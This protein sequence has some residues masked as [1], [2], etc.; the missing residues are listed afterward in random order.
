MITFKQYLTE[1]F[2]KTYSA[3]FDTKTDN[4]YTF[5]F[6]DEDKKKYYVHISRKKYNK[7]DYEGNVSFGVFDPETRETSYMPS[8]KAK[9]P[10]KVYATVFK[11]MKKYFDSYPVKVITFEAAHPATIPLY[12]KLAERLA[13][14]YNGNYY[15]KGSDFEVQL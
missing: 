12:K 5:H 8:G 4:E 2:D 11:G 14:E 6:F 1:L 13:R 15:Y 9:N 3:G 10:I 7:K